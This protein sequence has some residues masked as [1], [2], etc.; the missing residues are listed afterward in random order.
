MAGTYP[1]IIFQKRFSSAESEQYTSTT[2]MLKV[3]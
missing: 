3:E 2:E 1:V